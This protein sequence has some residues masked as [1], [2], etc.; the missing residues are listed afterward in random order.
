MLFPHLLVENDP[1]QVVIPLISINHK[2][3]V[4]VI[5]DD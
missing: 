1:R 5:V 3:S 4:D 2:N